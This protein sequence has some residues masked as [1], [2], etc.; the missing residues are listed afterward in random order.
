[1][2]YIIKSRGYGKTYDIVQLAS[3]NNGII[4]VPNQG[5]KYYIKCHFYKKYKI[6]FNEIDVLTVEEYLKNYSQ[7]EYKNRPI[8]ID[9]ADKCFTILFKNLFNAELNTIALTLS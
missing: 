3:S 6:S 1:M 7:K 8:Y 4:I 5:T 2:K 9:E